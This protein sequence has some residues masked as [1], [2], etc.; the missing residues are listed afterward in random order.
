MFFL[1]IMTQYEILYNL[2]MYM[3]DHWIFLKCRFSKSGMGLEMLH[4]WQ[5]PIP[6]GAAAGL[7]TFFFFFP[8]FRATPEAYGGSQAGGEIGAT[9]A[10]LHLSHSNAGSELHLQ[11][12]PQLTATP[13]PQHTE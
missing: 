5:A 4:F 1:N 9:A 12:I 8:L 13:D 2:N 6:A 11:S 10:S 7:R 3:G